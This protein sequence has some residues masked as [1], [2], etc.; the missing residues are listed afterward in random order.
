M[1][2]LNLA[3]PDKSEI[4]FKVD[5][6]PDGQ[7]NLTITNLDGNLK[8][9][10]WLANNSINQ[11]VKIKSRLN[12]FQDLEIICPIINS[13]NFESVTVMDSHSDV[14]EA[15][16]NNFEKEDNL[17]LVEFA[18]SSINPGKQFNLIVVDAGA[19]KRCDLLAQQLSKEYDI[20]LIQCHKK[21]DT[22]TGQIE[23]LEVYSNDLQN[24]PCIIVDDVADGA[25]SF[26]FCVQELQKIKGYKNSFLVVSNGIFSKGFSELSKY[27]EGIYCTNSYSD[28]FM[29][30]LKNK[31]GDLLLKQLY[32]F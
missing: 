13:L 9:D 10:I 20:N 18:L 32:V 16:L 11:P 23:K 30:G 7:R 12:N 1:K 26:I 24:L 4:K 6:Y 14:L 29:P 19:S 3:Y 8:S 2:E 27:F 28:N 15:C 5:H 22:K 25:N 17:E 31:N 21:R